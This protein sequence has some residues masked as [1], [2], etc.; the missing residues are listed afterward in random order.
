[1]ATSTLPQTPRSMAANSAAVP[2]VAYALGAVF[3]LGDAV[4]HVQQFAS[5]FYGVRWI[6]PLFI[7]NAVALVVVVA[8]LAY[9]RTRVL[10]ALSGVVL[11]AL[12]LGSLIVSYGNGLFGW[13]EVGFRTP[14]A[15]TVVFEVAAIVALTAA[16]ARR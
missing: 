13:Q 5:L 6:G 1:M 14:I 15:L 7:L 12:A 4:V 9:S 16:L 8:G 2:A 3:L 10:A 11:S